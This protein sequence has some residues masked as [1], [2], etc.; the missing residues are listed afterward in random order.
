[1]FSQTFLLE[2]DR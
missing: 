1:V 2:I